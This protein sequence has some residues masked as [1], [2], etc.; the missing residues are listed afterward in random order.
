VSGYWKIHSE[1]LSISSLVKISI[2][3][4]FPIR[5]WAWNFTIFWWYKTIHAEKVELEYLAELRLC[6]RC[7]RIQIEI[8]I[9]NIARIF[10][11][12]FIQD[13]ITITFWPITACKL[14]HGEWKAFGLDFFK[15]NTVLKIDAPL[16]VLAWI[17]SSQAGDFL[18]FL[19]GIVEYWSYIVAWIYLYRTVNGKLLT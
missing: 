6:A 17:F 12:G 3:W 4:L 19:A 8:N 15:P 1:I 13:K 10:W 7:F 14:S 2:L 16:A 18:V 11:L 9:K 5:F